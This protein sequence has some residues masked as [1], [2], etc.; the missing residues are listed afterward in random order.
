MQDHLEKDGCWG[1]EDNCRPKNAF[2]VPH[3]PGDH[4]GWVA[5]KKAQVDT[6]YAQGDFGYVRDQRKEMM[7]LCEPLFMVSFNYK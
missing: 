4:K 5:T 3:C 2:S 1:Y 6:F 7:P